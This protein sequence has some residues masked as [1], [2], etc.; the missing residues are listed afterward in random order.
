MEVKRRAM[1]ILFLSAEPTDEK[2][3]RLEDEVKA[4]REELE[5]SQGQANVEFETRAAVTPDDFLRSV[6]AVKPMVV[7]FSGHGTN[8]GAICLENENHEAHDVKP[9]ALAALF[10][11]ARQYVQCVIL[12]ACYSEVQAEAI[13]QHIPLVVGMNDSI[14]NQAAIAFSSGFYMAFGNQYAPEDAYEAGVT[15]LLLKNIPEAHKPVLHKKPPANPNLPSGAVANSGRLLFVPSRNLYFTGRD[16]EIQA[17]RDALTQDNAAG[18]SQAV[19]GMGGVGKTS[20][21]V[22]YAW[23]YGGEYERVVWLRAD[24]VASMRDGYARLARDL[25]LPGHDNQD[26]EAVIQAGRGW[27]S[28]QRDALLIL[29]NADFNDKYKSEDLRALLPNPGPKHRLITTRTPKDLTKLGVRKPYP[30]HTWD[31]DQALRYLMERVVG[32]NAVSTSEAA[33]AG[34]LAEAL[35][36]LPLALEQVAAYMALHESTFQ[37][38]LAMFRKQDIGWL[39]KSKPD[40]GEYERTVATTWNLSME[41]VERESQAS[42]DL[43][44]F[45]AFLTPDPI[46]AE[47][48]VRAP[49]QISQ[50][51][52]N[53]FS[54][55][56]N[57]SMEREAAY[58]AL[59]LP[60]LRYSLITKNSD[61]TFTVHR[62]LQAV[63]RAQRGSG[64]YE[65][66][67][68]CAIRTCNAS[69]PNAEYRYWF[70]YERLLQQSRAAAGFIESLNLA[71]EPAG[72][73]LCNLSVYLAQRGQ[74]ED[75]IHYAEICV[76]TYKKV[77]PGEH[78]QV[79]TSINNL[80]GFYE[81]RRWYEKSL[82]LYK[83][84]LG[85]LRNSSPEVPAKVAS[86]INNIADIYRR[87]GRYDEAESLFIEALG[88]DEE[89]YGRDHYEVATDL[90]NIALLYLD[91][92]RY[93]EAELLFNESLETRRRTLPDG[94]PNI[95]VSLNN[96]ASLY[97]LQGRY[98]DAE[99]L[100]HEAL[101]RHRQVLGGEH[102]S[103]RMVEDNYRHF[104]KV[105]RRQA[106]SL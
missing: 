75:A 6:L 69:L 73:L 50:S 96:L 7:H 76:V 33:A 105:K 32:E 60:L 2:P 24:S 8:T 31:K 45:C 51:I 35:G 34:E 12:N 86:T 44:R 79:A 30:L 100:L 83:E 41:A 93:K 40:A 78:H 55:C 88:I 52:Y 90:N 97:L 46:P 91:L 66:G 29:D 17:I 10:K 43:L 3:L 54:A 64:N 9:E 81:S 57:D 20:L 104:L 49:V 13:S 23:R 5:R 37:N 67:I 62:L 63:I 99:P 72:T 80:A 22:E 98:S 19:S 71:S 56:G 68:H 26:A 82:Q 85:I 47:L 87:Q 94:D 27:L 84:A 21:A 74:H 4:I 14:G 61:H 48:I 1:R 39:E 15:A 103:T 92:H 53:H 106:R 38:Y 16:T 65:D 95:A 77:L 36:G 11:I 25:T 58:D 42:A 101:E 89:F 59:L 102:P 18:I 70:L 28:Q